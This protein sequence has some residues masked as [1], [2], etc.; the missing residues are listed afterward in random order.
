CGESLWHKVL[1]RMC[2][3]EDARAQFT[4]S[5]W[6]LGLK[7][8]L[9]GEG[10]SMVP[11]FRA[12]GLEDGQEQVEELDAAAK[13][14][15]VARYALEAMAAN[16]QLITGL[17]SEPFTLAVTGGRAT[18][19]RAF[20]EQVRRDQDLITQLADVARWHTEQEQKVALDQIQ[21]IGLLITV[22]GL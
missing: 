3:H 14:V 21:A 19:T 1:S 17:I 18:A 11:A 16:L 8:A 12:G 7:E 6:A 22:A 20:I 2:R 13:Y 10:R 5:K 4:S 15:A 9:G